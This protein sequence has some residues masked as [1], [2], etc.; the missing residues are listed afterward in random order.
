MRNWGCR[1]VFLTNSTFWM[2]A[3]S[4]FS[5]VQNDAYKAWELKDYLLMNIMSSVLTNILHYYSTPLGGDSDIKVTGRGN[6]RKNWKEPLKGT[7]FCFT[8]KA[9]VCFC[10]V[11]FFTSKRNQNQSTDIYFL[12]YVSAQY[13]KEYHHPLTEVILD[14]STP[15]ATT[16]RDH[17]RHPYMRA[18]P[19]IQHTGCLPFTWENRLVHGLGNW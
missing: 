2:L 18:P 4:V 1:W 16:P 10:F 17:S 19:G 7:E 9:V 15:R 3:T 5:F 6:R 12:S 13:P 14:F 8:C 11:L